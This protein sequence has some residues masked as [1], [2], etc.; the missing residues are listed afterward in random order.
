M[1]RIDVTDLHP[2]LRDVEVIAACNIKNVLLGERG[3]ARVFGPQKG[4]TPEQVKRLE[5]GLTMYAAC[6]LEGFGV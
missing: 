6:L 1:E 5:C 3:V 2:R 4:A